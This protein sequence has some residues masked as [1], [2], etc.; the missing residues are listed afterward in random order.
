M[1][2]VKRIVAVLLLAAVPVFAGVT[3][4]SAQRFSTTVDE[5]ETVRSSIYSMGKTIDI[6][7]KIEGDVFCAGQS[8]TIEAEVWGD[9]ICAGMDV[10]IAGKVHGDIRV[11]GQ[12]VTIEAQTEQSVTVAAQKFSLDV[13]A[14]VGRDLTATGDNMNIKGSVGRDVLS[15]ANEV[16]FN[17]VVGRDVK[18]NGTKIRL[19]QD[20][21]IAGNFTYSSRSDAEMAKDAVV[22]GITKKETPKQE[23]RSWLSK[24]S[25]SFYLFILFGVLL[26]ALVL[27]HFFPRF[28]KKGST[29]IQEGFAKTL[30]VGLAASFIVPMLALGLIFSIVGI[31]LVLFML[32]GW[33]FGAMLS[34]PIAAYFAGSLILRRRTQNPLL[35][36]TVGSIVLVTAFFLPL[37]GILF[38]MLAYWLGFGSLILSLKDASRPMQPAETVKATKASAAKTKK[39]TTKK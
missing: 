5:N 16:T 2:Y 11:A 39:R 9:V 25:V 34:V 20:A 24:F 36:A 13:G 32:V 18:A 37:M 12:T 33:I 27:A 38:V 28:I 8:V 23:N 14:V 35:I 31:P 26:I 15:S 6:N 21:R 7:G 3:L 10:T 22:M 17:G 19:K 30:V 4:A 29:Y 1:K